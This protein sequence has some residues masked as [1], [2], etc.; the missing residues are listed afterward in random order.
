MIT[1]ELYNELDHLCQ[2]IENNSAKLVDYQ[3][4]EFLLTQGGLSRDYIFSYL[5]RAGFNNWQDLINA[6]D[7]QETKEIFKAVAIG[8][9]VGLGLGLILTGLFGGKK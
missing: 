9:L 8:G 3:R 2:K 1:V 6:R 5:N 4:Y 7:N